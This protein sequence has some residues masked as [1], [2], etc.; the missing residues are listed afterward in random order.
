MRCLRCESDNPPGMKFCGKCGP[1]LGTT[2][3]RCGAE[4]PPG[5][6]LCGEC[7]SSLTEEPEEPQRPGLCP[8]GIHSSPPD[9][10][11]DP[12]R[13]GGRAKADLGVVLRPGGLDRPGGRLGPETMH[14]LLN[15]FF[16]LAL[17]RSPSF[18]G[19]V[20]CHCGRKM[21]V[22]S[23]SPKWTCYSCRNKIPIPGLS[24]A[25]SFPR[26]PSPSILHEVDTVVREK[27]D[28]LLTLR[29]GASSIQAEAGETLP[30]LS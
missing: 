18:T 8:S 9:G 15:R 12:G 25:S 17:D 26:T 10:P 28:L 3:P 29:A 27:G 4:N 22:P 6:K 23:N 1:K 2:C 7:G 24:R 14:L 16:E 13:P 11:P 20:F 21:Y 5:F 19:V 30:S